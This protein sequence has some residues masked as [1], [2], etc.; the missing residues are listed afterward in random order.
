MRI[1]ITEVVLL[2]QS[3]AVYEG[4]ILRIWFHNGAL[5]SRINAHARQ[6]LVKMY[7]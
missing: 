6:H 7:T 4:Y 1:F 2:S 3:L 5:T